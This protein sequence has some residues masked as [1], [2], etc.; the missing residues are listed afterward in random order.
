MSQK[1]YPMTKA[2]PQRSHLQFMLI[3]RLQTVF[4]YNS[5]DIERN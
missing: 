5:T 1:G 4:M 2:L 3:T